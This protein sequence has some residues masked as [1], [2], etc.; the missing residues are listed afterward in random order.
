MTRELADDD[1]AAG[2]RDPDELACRCLPLRVG[3]EAEDSDRE[4]DIELPLVEGKV[5]EICLDEPR[6]RS[7][8]ARRIEQRSVVVDA[9]DGKP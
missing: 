2:P 4:R 9:G 6:L 8:A 3:E 5:R 7:P 1:S